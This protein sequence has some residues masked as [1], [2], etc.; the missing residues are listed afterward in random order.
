[1]SLMPCSWT[2][3]HITNAATPQPAESAGVTVTQSFM[4]NLPVQI[5]V[6]TIGVAMATGV[7]GGLMES[8]SLHVVTISSEP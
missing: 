4:I 2:K 5:M 3:L 6:K 7:L 8:E 1:M